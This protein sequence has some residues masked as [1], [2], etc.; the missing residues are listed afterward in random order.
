MPVATFGPTTGWSGKT[1]TYEAGVFTL[2]EHGVITTADV[3]SYDEKGQL[4]WALS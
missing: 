3:L 4:I 1:I 2:E